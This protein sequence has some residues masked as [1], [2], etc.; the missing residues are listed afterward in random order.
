MPSQEQWSGRRLLLWVSGRRRRTP[1][2]P[3][4][5]ARK[6]LLR[7]QSARLVVNFCNDVHCGCITGLAQDPLG[8]VCRRQ[9]ARSIAR[10][11]H[12]KRTS[13]IESSGGTR[14][15]SLWRQAVECSARIPSIPD[16]GGPTSARLLGTG[17]GVGHQISPLSSSR[18]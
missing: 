10:V 17:R 14:S 2:S 6:A 12:L 5:S 4:K 7:K 8:I 1:R 3:A 9:P 15:V 18:R 13:L 11:F 16:R